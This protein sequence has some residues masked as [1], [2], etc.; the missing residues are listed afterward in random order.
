MKK[1]KIPAWV[2]KKIRECS[3]KTNDI[4]NRIH[5]AYLND[6]SNRFDKWIIA[7]PAEYVLAMKCGYEE[8]L[9]YIKFCPNDRYAYLKVFK[10]DLSDKSKWQVT[11]KDETWDL[12]TKFTTDEIN[13][14]F[15]Q[16]KPFSI[17]VDDKNE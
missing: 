1:V 13:H 3:T 17:K 5:D 9:Y 6:S 7:N 15:P 14:Y 16:F 11:S 4:N 10:G 12:Q 2:A 8:E